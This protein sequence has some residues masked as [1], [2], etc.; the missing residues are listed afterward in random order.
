MFESVYLSSR[1]VVMAA[2]P[3]RVVADIPIEAPYPRT[4]AFRTSEPYNHYCR[5]VSAALKTAM[6]EAALG[7]SG[8]V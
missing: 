2:R 8:H 1:I 7:E 5:I 3:G 6:G 4:E